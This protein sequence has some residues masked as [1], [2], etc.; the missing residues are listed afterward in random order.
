MVG[1]PLNFFCWRRAKVM[2][3][4]SYCISWPHNKSHSCRTSVVSDFWLHWH[5]I[6]L[7]IT[8]WIY[9]E[10]K[11][12]IVAQQH[13]KSRC[14]LMVILWSVYKHRCSILSASIKKF[15]CYG[16]SR[17]RSTVDKIE[18]RRWETIRPQARR[19]SSTRTKI[20]AKNLR[21]AMG[22]QKQI[23]AES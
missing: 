23:D 22:T 7:C 6:Q 17:K 12:R 16:F 1:L 10:T 19:K 11:R 3:M 20:L 18:S 4:H 8:K 5:C 15:D 14:C 13:E 2:M 21:E 9:N